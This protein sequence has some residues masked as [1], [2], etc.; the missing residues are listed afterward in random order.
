MEQ[1]VSPPVFA[2]CR[3]SHT[4]DSQSLLFPENL[5]LSRVILWN[6]WFLSSSF[7]HH[8]RTLT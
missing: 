7:I 5:F 4:T 2:I 8:S 1:V 6:R 3:S